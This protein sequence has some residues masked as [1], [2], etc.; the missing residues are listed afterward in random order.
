[1]YN[2]KYILNYTYPIQKVYLFFCRDLKINNQDQS[3]SDTL[4]QPIKNQL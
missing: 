2:G 1:M 4:F 3:I